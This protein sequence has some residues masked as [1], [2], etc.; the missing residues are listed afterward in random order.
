MLYLNTDFAGPQL[1]DVCAREG[2]SVLVHDEEYTELAAPI[3]AE[4]ILAW[5]D[6]A[7]DERHD[8]LEAADPRA[9]RSAS[10]APGR[11][12]PRSCC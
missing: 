8:S 10:A 2:I 9:R 4:R 3:E 11:S 1:R 7:A 5:T 6:R 12:R